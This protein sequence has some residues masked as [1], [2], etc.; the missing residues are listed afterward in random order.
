[1]ERS[2][3]TSS[4]IHVGPAVPFAEV[5]GGRLLVIRL[6]KEALATIFDEGTGGRNARGTYSKDY[7]LRHPEVKWV[8]RGQGRYLPVEDLKRDAAPGPQRRSR[9]SRVQQDATDASIVKS[10]PLDDDDEEFLIQERIR[11]VVATYVPLSRSREDEQKAQDRLQAINSP[12]VTADPPSWI[13]DMVHSRV[14]AHAGQKRK[15]GPDSQ[16]RTDLAIWTEE[17]QSRVKSVAADLSPQPLLAGEEAPAE[18][19]TK[20]REYM[21][22][23]FLAVP[24]NGATTASVVNELQSPAE[25]RPRK[26]R[27]VEETLSDS[28]SHPPTLGLRH[29]L[30]EPQPQTP[31]ATEE[32]A[33][34]LLRRAKPVPSIEKA[35][36]SALRSEYTA[37]FEASAS[38]DEDTDNMADDD[39]ET[40]T[41]TKQYVDDHQDERFYHT[42]NGWYKKGKRPRSK[43]VCD[44]AAPALKKGRDG[45]FTF[46]GKRKSINQRDLEKYPG[47]EFHHC[48]NGYFRPGPDPTGKRTSITVPG[49]RTEEEEEPEQEQEEEHNDGAA[50]GTVSRDYK[51]A[52]P[53]FE[54]VHRGGGR[55]VR[56]ASVNN[57]AAPVASVTPA[58]ALT[59][60]QRRKSET[61]FDKAYVDAHPHEDFYHSGNARWRRGTKASGKQNLPENES[62]EEEEQDTALYDKTYVLAHPRELFHHRGQGRY[63][64]GP[65]PVIR[66]APEEVEQ[67]DSEE[68]DVDD[69]ALHNLVNREYVDAHPNLNFHHRGQGRWAHGLAP[70]GSH[71]KV[72]VRGPN[73]KKMVP[74]PSEETNEAG[75]KAPDITALVTRAEGPEKFPNITFHYRGGGKW[76]RITKLEWEQMT[77]P[78]TKDYKVTTFSKYNGKR[79]TNK[80]NGGVDREAAP[81]G[82]E[83]D[84]GL[85]YADD[86]DVDLPPVVEKPKA[87]RRRRNQYGVLQTREEIAA[88]RDSSKPQSKAATPPKPRMLEPDEDIIND[89]DLPTLWDDID[90]D[91]SQAGGTLRKNFMPIQLD[92]MLDVL[93]RHDPVVRSLDN[94]NRIAEHTA[95]MLA[96]LQEEYVALDTIVA[97]HAKV[98]RRPAKGG[99]LPVDPAIFEDRKEAELYDYIYDP[100]KIGFQ[101][102]EAQRIVR[103][104]EGRELRKR[105]NRSGI[106]PTDT[107][108]GWH[109]GE[110]AELASKR[111]SRQPNR[112]EMIA[113]KQPRKRARTALNGD[114]QQAES[115]TPDRTATPLLGLGGYRRPV[116]ATA[117]GGSGNVHKRVQELRDTSVVSMRSSDAGPDGAKIRKGRP[118]GSKNLHKRSDAGIKKGPRKKRVALEPSVEASSSAPARGFAMDWAVGKGNEVTAEME[119]GLFLTEDDEAM[120]A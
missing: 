25:R 16:P 39:D 55:Y 38:E 65:K 119:Q 113:E 34:R 84:E 17:R 26:R 93:N 58:A 29:R 40:P 70:A 111:Q 96:Q 57:N 63:A 80:A 109:F 81:I 45:S 99:R 105:R 12:S 42:G 60:E 54:W 120:G 100:R 36:R 98:P 31:S 46:E 3:S 51:D 67:S 107:V 101:D 2:A 64:R 85:F 78:N 75:E 8:H 1:M 33:A 10:E 47:V 48:G 73:S 91:D 115:M 7:T 21:D 103:D 4:D 13:K 83:D 35:S 49:V 23:L 56:K 19:V 106:E 20:Y 44:S 86:M 72:A 97:P 15:M 24:E 22:R 76:G 88:S 118:P 71:N 32:R 41:Y 6:G 108:P 28:L 9:H 95:K 90:P 77:A 68:S 114:G 110:G 59:C 5:R 52:H 50:G 66:P 14:M 69:T 18:R 92:R 61:T 43:P 89:A 30:S 53:E 94:L 82:G 104:A 117:S 27:A 102:P 116:V 112:F 62:E 37:V 11:N 87:T 79:G 74:R